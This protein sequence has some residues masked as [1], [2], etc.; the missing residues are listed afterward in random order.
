[1]TQLLEV[2]EQ[3]LQSMA[4]LEHGQRHRKAFVDRHCHILDKQ[5]KI[6]QPV[7][8]RIQWTRPFWIIHTYNGT[9]QLRTL[10]RELLRQWV[11]GFRLKPYHGPTQ[12][13]PF[14]C[15]P[16]NFRQPHGSYTYRTR[17]YPAG[18]PVTSNQFKFQKRN[19]KNEII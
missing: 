11:N 8:T 7:L 12:P 15:T 18:I 2:G 10:A 16:A 5:F 14:P 19:K 1:M 17:G 3:R 13:N 9:F 4:Q 6:G